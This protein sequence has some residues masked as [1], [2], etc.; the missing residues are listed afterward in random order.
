[1]RVEAQRCLETPGAPPPAV[2]LRVRGAEQVVDRRVTADRPRSRARRELD[3]FGR[4]GRAETPRRPRSNA[5]PRGR[6]RSAAARA[7]TASSCAVSPASAWSEASCSSAAGWSG[8]RRLACLRRVDRVGPRPDRRQQLRR[9]D[10]TS[11]E[12]RP[13]RRQRL[14]PRQRVRA[15]A[16]EHRRPHKAVERAASAGRAERAHVVVVGRAHARRAFAI[17]RR[18]CA[19]RRRRRGPRLRIDRRAAV[20][21]RAAPRAPRRSRRALRRCSSRG[22]ENSSVIRSSVERRALRRSARAPP[23][24]RRRAT[25]SRTARRADTVA[26]SA[27][28]P[29]LRPVAL[30]VAEPSRRAAPSDATSS[31]S[32]PPTSQAVPFGKHRRNVATIERRS[33][34]L[35][36]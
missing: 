4:V 33:A 6:A 10:Q 19:T 24:R 2:Q 28:T 11:A 29:G 12:A 36:L 5:W 30:D 16:D 7:T 18:G 9:R 35:M 26:R 17:M 23:G 20:G 8:A 22:A 21:L 13:V 15:A 3:R 25:R 34:S 31:T 32:S 27:A 14:D 1:M